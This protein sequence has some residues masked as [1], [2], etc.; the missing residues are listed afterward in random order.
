[1]RSPCRRTAS[2]ST[3]GRVCSRRGRAPSAFVRPASQA[4]HVRRGRVEHSLKGFH[5]R[6]LRSVAGTRTRREFKDLRAESGRTVEAA[7]RYAAVLIIGLG[8]ER[9]ADNARGLNADWRGKDAGKVGVQR[10]AAVGQISGAV[11]RMMALSFI[12]TVVAVLMVVVCANRVRNGLRAG[13]RRRDDARE[14]RDD[15]QGDQQPHKPSYRPKPI[16]PRRLDQ[17][18]LSAAYCGLIAFGRQCLL[19][20]S[21]GRCSGNSGAVASAREPGDPALQQSNAASYDGYA[22]SAIRWRT[23]GRRSSV[24]TNSTTRCAR[25]SPMTGVALARNLA[26]MAA[27]LIGLPAVPLAWGT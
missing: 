10:A 23:S 7:R 1:L 21:Y 25:S 11:A 26:S 13:V 5:A 9:L 27:S 19:T 24:H 3:A 12:A 14:L 4:R 16:H 2:A 8:G 15:E 17:S 20:A 22:T 18:P 6:I